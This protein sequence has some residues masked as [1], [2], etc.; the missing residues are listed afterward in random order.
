MMNIGEWMKSFGFQTNYTDI[1]TCPL[2]LIAL[3]NA[4]QL[5]RSV[6]P[7]LSAKGTLGVRLGIRDITG[8]AARG[9][10]KLSNS[11]NILF[12]VVMTQQ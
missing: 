4:L 1:Y 11:W 8:K 2:E 12:S 9:L 3:R 7:L 5:L 6:I 10:A